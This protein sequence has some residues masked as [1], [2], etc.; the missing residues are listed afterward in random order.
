MLFVFLHTP[1][2]NTLCFFILLSKY[3]GRPTFGEYTMNILSLT[4]A[5]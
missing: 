5:G 2:D 3:F 1:P 4:S